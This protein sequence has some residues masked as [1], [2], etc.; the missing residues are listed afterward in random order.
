MN[1]RI[2]LRDGLITIKDI[3]EC[4]VKGNGKKLGIKLPAWSILQCLLAS[5]KSH[6]SGLV[7]C[8]FFLILYPQ[9]DVY[10]FVFLI[11]IIVIEFCS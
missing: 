2:L 4:I 3:E 8:K 9:C 5:A 10:Y 6:S 7:I 11:T 1:G